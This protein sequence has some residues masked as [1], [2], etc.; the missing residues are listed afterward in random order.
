MMANS[1]M[2]PATLV[3]IGALVSGLNRSAFDQDAAGKGEWRCVSRNA[4]Q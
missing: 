3:S 2:K 1:A 4:D